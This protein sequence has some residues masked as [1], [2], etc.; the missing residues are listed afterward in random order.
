MKHLAAKPYTDRLVKQ[1]L[2]IQKLEVGLFPHNVDQVLSS[3]IIMPTGRAS[4]RFLKAFD[5]LGKL[6]LKLKHHK[7][8]SVGRVK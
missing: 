7:G 2:F 6:P 8:S 1:K 3:S 4:N 5:K